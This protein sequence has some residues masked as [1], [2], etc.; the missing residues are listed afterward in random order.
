[1][2][3]LEETWGCVLVEINGGLGVILEGNGEILDLGDK[4]KLE[5]ELEVEEVEGEAWWLNLCLTD[6]GKLG[7]L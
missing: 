3:V 7:K 2:L 5:L 6:G 1:M 4:S